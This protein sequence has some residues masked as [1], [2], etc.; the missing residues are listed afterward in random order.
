VEIELKSG[1]DNCDPLGLLNFLGWQVRPA[2][3]FR[4]PIYPFLAGRRT[5]RVAWLVLAIVTL[6]APLIN[7]YSLTPFVASKLGER[8][9]YTTIAFY[10]ASRVAELS[11]KGVQV[12]RA[13]QAERARGAYLAQV[14]GRL[15]APLE[16]IAT[17]LHGSFE[18]RTQAKRASA[19]GYRLLSSQGRLSDFEE[20]LD[21]IVGSFGAELRGR[22]TR[23]PGVVAGRALAEAI[24]VALQSCSADEAIVTISEVGARAR[25]ALVH[26]TGSGPSSRAFETIREIVTP[27]GGRVEVPTIFQGGGARVVVCV[28]TRM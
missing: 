7:G 25:V 26:A 5:G 1:I 27:V 3:H 4:P 9:L 10:I 2:G 23:D 11:V 15:L 22:L 13:I 12:E 28:P 6:T 21:F 14:T 8:L 19:W 16:A 24:G 18:V 17:D 20:S